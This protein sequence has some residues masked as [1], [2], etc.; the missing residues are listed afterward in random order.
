MLFELI[1]CKFILPNE[2]TSL[3]SKKKILLKQWIQATI[4]SIFPIKEVMINMWEV[5]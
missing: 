5:N 1:L 4:E 3:T 2:N